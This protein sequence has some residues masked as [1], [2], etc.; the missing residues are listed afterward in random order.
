MLKRFSKASVVSLQSGFMVVLTVYQV[1]EKLSDLC[2][3]IWASSR[4]SWRRR[5][6][7]GR[8]GLGDATGVARLIRTG[9]T[10]NGVFRFTPVEAVT[11]VSGHS[12]CRQ[13]GRYRHSM[14]SDLS[15]HQQFGLYWCWR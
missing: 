5:C 4:R 14:R 12:K 8:I 13:F 3:I 11:E 2:K 9:S 7:F 15:L 1:D 10:R 6:R